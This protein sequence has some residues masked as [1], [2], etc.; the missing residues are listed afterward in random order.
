[1]KDKF[2]IAVK[3]LKSDAYFTYEG[4]PPSTEEEYNNVKWITNGTSTD[5][6]NYGSA[7]SEIT[8]TKVKEE[9]DKL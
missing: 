1:M 7:P 2:L 9:M 3:T 4:N 6:A 5:A 8:W